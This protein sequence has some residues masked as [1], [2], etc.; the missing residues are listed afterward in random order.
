MLPSVTVILQEEGIRGLFAGFTSSIL[1]S[2]IGQT[3][4]FGAYEGFKRRLMDA[5]VNPQVSYFVSGGLADVVASIAYVPSE[6]Y[7]L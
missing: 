7:F 3:F 2:L 6:V 5:Q 4:Y 1:G